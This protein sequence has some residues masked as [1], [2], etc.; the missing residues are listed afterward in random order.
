MFNSS[1]IEKKVT[2][3]T[4][5]YLRDHSIS[6]VPVIPAVLAIEWVVGVAKKVKPN[7]FVQKCSDFRVLKGISIKGF[8]QEETVFQLEYH[9]ENEGDF[10]AEV[11]I[12]VISS[13]GV[14]HYQARVLMGKAPTLVNHIDPNYEKKLQLSQYTKSIAETNR[15]NLFHGKEFQF[16]KN[17][18]GY[19]DIGMKA[20]LAPSQSVGYR[21]HGWDTDIAAFEGGLQ[22][23]AIWSRWQTKGSALPSGFKELK[24]YEA[25]DAEGP[26]HCLMKGR[27]INQFSVEFDLIFY[28][29]KN[30]VFAELNKLSATM[31]PWDYSVKA[32]EEQ[33]NR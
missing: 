16:I 8:E 15:E 29:A 11:V 28:N 32:T 4:H 12:K 13:A 10:S 17:I 5:A 19:S 21:I 23:A 1:C 7:W 9:V 22:M 2:P 25:I 20:E 3:E 30:Q 27:V 6:G 24:I 18:I 33:Y 31:L 14:L 26:V